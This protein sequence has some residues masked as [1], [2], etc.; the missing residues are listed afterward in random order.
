MT[1][2]SFTELE[3]QANAMIQALTAQRNAAMDQVVNLLG[4]VAILEART[5]A[6]GPPIEATVQ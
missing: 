5:K 1:D 4:Q 3:A 2:K 6:S